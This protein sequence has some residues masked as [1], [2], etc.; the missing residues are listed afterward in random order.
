MDNL[1]SSFEP[2]ARLHFRLDLSWLLILPATVWANINL[3]VP[4][5]GA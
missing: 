2:Q 1:T 4:I 3:Y 5:L